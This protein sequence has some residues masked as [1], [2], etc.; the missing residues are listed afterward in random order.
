MDC[1][2]KILFL[3]HLSNSRDGLKGRY[4][5]RATRSQTR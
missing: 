1:I 4:E 2:G 5:P 3:I